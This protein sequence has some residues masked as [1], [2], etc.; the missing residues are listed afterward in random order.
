MFYFS[1]ILTIISYVLMRISISKYIYYRD[2]QCEFPANEP[3]R[4]Q[5]EY[6]WKW[7]MIVCISAFFVTAFGP[8][9]IKL[10]M[11]WT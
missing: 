11:G 10:Y 3:Y 5:A 4:K 8:L 9:V 7:A 1:L 2:Y 6:N